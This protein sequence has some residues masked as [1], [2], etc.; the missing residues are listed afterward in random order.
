MVV[1]LHIKKPSFPFTYTCEGFH[2]SSVERAELKDC[3]IAANESN[4]TGVVL[5]GQLYQ[6]MTSGELRGYIYRNDRINRVWSV[7][8]SV[9]RG[10]QHG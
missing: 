9:R 3:T 6:G 2:G 4:M 7:S 8:V 10:W 5:I 1:F